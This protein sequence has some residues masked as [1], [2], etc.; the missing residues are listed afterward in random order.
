MST[1]DAVNN[2]GRLRE[3]ILENLVEAPGAGGNEAKER[4]LSLVSL[5]HT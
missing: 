1:V 3:A 2:L 5:E 4:A